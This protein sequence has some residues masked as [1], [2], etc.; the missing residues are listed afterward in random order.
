MDYIKEF[1][2]QQIKK[3]IPN[4]KPGDT[5]IVKVWIVEGTKKKNTSV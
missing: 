4:F 5:I 3:N 2:S 1:E